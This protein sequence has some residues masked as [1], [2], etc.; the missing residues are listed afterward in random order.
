LYIAGIIKADE[1]RWLLTEYNEIYGLNLNKLAI[2]QGIQQSTSAAGTSI[3]SV[4]KIL[5]T[6]AQE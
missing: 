4:L 6:S 3:D 5:L 2:D 1:C